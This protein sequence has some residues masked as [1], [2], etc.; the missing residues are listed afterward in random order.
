MRTCLLAIAVVLGSAAPVLAQGTGAATADLDRDS[1]AAAAEFDAAAPLETGS[2]QLPRPLA[3]DA[4]NVFLRDAGPRRPAALVGLYSA[5]A[6]LNVLDVY[7]T[8]QAL[9]NGAREANPVMARAGARVGT[10]IAL[11]AI[12]TSGSIYFTEKL[13]KKNRV[14]AIVTMAALNAGTAVVIARNFRNARS[15]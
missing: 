6:G 15:R 9:G 7:S 4:E 14:A 13:W 8:T 1:L 11:K 3:E 2:L 5:L 10:A 12:S